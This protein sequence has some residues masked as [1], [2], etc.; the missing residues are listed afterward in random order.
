MKHNVLFTPE[1]I[2]QQIQ[3]EITEDNENDH[4]DDLAPEIQQQA[5]HTPFFEN[6]R[7]V[8][9]LHKEADT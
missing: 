3:A 4:I 6:N 5:D 7:S 1:G 9:M 2:Q 8:E